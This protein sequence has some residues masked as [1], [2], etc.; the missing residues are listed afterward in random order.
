MSAQDDNTILEFNPTKEWLK[1]HKVKPKEC[2]SPDCICL[3][4]HFNH[5]HQ[6]FCVGYYPHNGDLDMVSL[7]WI[8]WD[9]ETQ[10]LRRQNALMH[11]SE[12]SL[13]AT[14]IQFASGVMWELIPDYRKQIGEMGRKRTRDIKRRAKGASKEVSEEV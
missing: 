5:N 10:E 9:S 11:P 8:S 13:M 4:D 6:G 14:F 2:E 7:C 3:I 12:A 1:R